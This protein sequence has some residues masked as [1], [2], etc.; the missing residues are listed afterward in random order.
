MVQLTRARFERWQVLGPTKTI[1]EIVLELL[2]KQRRDGSWT[3][4]A[5]EQLTAD[6]GD[7]RILCAPTSFFDANP[8]GRILNR[9]SMEVGV[10]DD[11]LPQTAFDFLQTTLFCIAI[12]L[13][14]YKLLDSER[15]D[16]L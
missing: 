15:C 14:V 11:A 4:D 6:L 9:F 12:V 7:R 16:Q 8:S 10:C 5:A 13:L 1:A 3:A 2:A